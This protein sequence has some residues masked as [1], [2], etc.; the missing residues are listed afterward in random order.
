MLVDTHAGISTLVDDLA[1]AGASC[2]RSGQLYCGATWCFYR[3]LAP[4][5]RLKKPRYA[6]SSA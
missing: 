5:T 6:C 1:R 4:L 3:L 2:W